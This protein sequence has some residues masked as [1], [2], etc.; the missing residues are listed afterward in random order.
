MESCSLPPPLISKLMFPATSKPEDFSVILNV[1]KEQIK[2]LIG[3]KNGAYAK[4]SL[5]SMRVKHVL[6]HAS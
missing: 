5:T 2:G 3:E 1:H 4:K 6:T